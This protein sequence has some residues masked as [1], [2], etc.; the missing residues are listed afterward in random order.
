M[1]NFLG[2]LSGSGAFDGAGAVPSG[3][4]LSVLALELPP[5]ITPAIAGLTVGAFVG[6]FGFIA[7][8]LLV[9][10]GNRRPR[11]RRVSMGADQVVFIPPYEAMQRETPM[12]PQAFSVV[13]STG[14]AGPFV[15]S[16]SLSARAFAKMGYEVD[17]ADE[18]DG[19]DADPFLSIEVEMLDE[20][21]LMDAET[22]VPQAPAVIVQPVVMLSSTTPV[23][24]LRSAE[25]SA[26]HPLGIIKSTSAAMRAAPIAD[27][28]F[29]DGPTQIGETY[30]DEPPQPRRRTDPPKIRPIAV[31]GPR[32]AS[33]EQTPLLPQ[34]TP[35]PMRTAPRT[36]RA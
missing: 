35:P 33:P 1:M 3:T 19:P 20:D 22:P 10:R 4:R 5:A 29:D 2:F 17:V 25:K 14:R 30:F 24:G 15:P 32:F 16:S 21:D 27:L 18:R 12:P 23:N 8:L 6:V 11:T 7:V 34:V 36:D 31:K 9:G 26:P 28:A 13:R